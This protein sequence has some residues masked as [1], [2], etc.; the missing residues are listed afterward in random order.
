MSLLASHPAFG[1]PLFFGFSARE[2]ATAMPEK[3]RAFV[4]NLRASTLFAIFALFA[5]AAA[6]QSQAPPLLE[7]DDRYKAD[8]LLVVAH[9]DDDVVIGG[10]LARAAL[11]E[12]KR[13]AVIYCTRGDGGGN[14]VGNEA[15][16]ALGELREMEARRALAAWEIENVWFLNGHD[17][18]GQNV[19]RSLDNWNH[20][21]ALDQVVRIVRIT[22]P[23]VILTWLPDA[24]VG[25]NHDDH[26]A[27]AVLAV[28]AFDAAGDLTKFP[29]QVSPPRDRTGMAN[30][31]EGLLPWQ[32]KK[33]YFF[34]DAF[35]VWGPYWHDPAEVPP[36]RKTIVDHTGPAY[37]TK[38][39]SPSRHESYAQLN[40]EQ[41]AFYLTQEGDLGVNAL[42]TGRFAY[43]AHLIFGKSLVGGS[44]TGDVFE[45]VKPG[46]IPFARV[47][48][49]EPD[50]RTGL[51]FEIG[52][53]WRFYSLFWKAHD[54][55]RLA[56]LIPT[57]EAAPGDDGKLTLDFVACN[58]TAN[59]A[60]FAIAAKLPDG[61]QEQRAYKQYPVRAGQCYPIQ[62]RLIAPP[63]AT[64]H[65][66]ELTWT[67]TADGKSGGSVTV[68]VFVGKKG[69]LPQ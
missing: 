13:I 40:A 9:P 7:P 53:P 11:D 62:T 55:D 32:P 44:T 16:A 20:G 69:A 50:E 27:S 56:Q 4:M 60:Q 31:T 36:F 26:Q 51:S 5:R 22:R 6:A 43:H 58:D 17:T 35:E 63:A 49:Y 18:P 38:A 29:E 21:T 65:W 42:K 3:K 47:R 2:M 15:G 33:L 52:D 41:Q 48:G 45:G 67:A 30:L 57:P 19:L 10:Y 61:W 12:H 14:S 37:D 8:L 59:S 54:L 25:E 34:S 66:D 28:E 68:R 1:F 24:V 23:E 64:S 46:S 39:V